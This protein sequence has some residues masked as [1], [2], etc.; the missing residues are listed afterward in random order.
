MDSKRYTIGLDFGTLSARAVLADVS[1]GNIV[2]VSVFGYQDMVIE[3]YLPDTEIKVPSDFALQNPEDY[4]AATTCLLHDI[5]NKAGID[6]QNVIGIGVGFTASTVIAVDEEYTP[7]CMKPEFCSNPHSWVK[8]WKHHGARQEAELINELGEKRQDDF[9]KKYGGK[10]NA[11]LMIPKIFE[12]YRKAPQIYQAT[13]KFMEAS[14]WIVWLLCG[15]ECRSSSSAGLKAFWNKK[16]GYPCKEFFE[17]MDEEFGH[18]V[19]EKLESPVESIGFRAGYLTEKM[20]KETGLHTGVAVSVGASDAV[21]TFPA[22]SVLKENQ[23]ILTLGT[24]ACYQTNNKKEICVPGILGVVEDAMIQGYYGYDAGL[25]AVGDLF[26]WFA[27]RIKPNSSFQQ[28][29]EDDMSIFDVLNQK[30]E[31]LQPGQS[32]LVA[33]DWWNG[34]RSVLGNSDLTGAIIG[35]NLST[36]P[37]EIYRALIE[38]TAFG[39]RVIHENFEKNGIFAEGFVACGGLA[40]KSKTVMQIM[41]DVLGQ[42]IK[43]YDAPQAT[44][45]G[46]AIYG[47]VAAGVEHGGYSNIF[48][49]GGNMGQKKCKI[50]V[51]NQRAHKIYNQLFEI[52]KKLYQYFGVE[53][54]ETMKL[55]KDKK[56]I[57]KEIIN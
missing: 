54:V 19:L 25:T 36:K 32:G 12:T 45:L 42:E 24:S 50:Y 15:Q 16:T 11:E 10:V 53:E 5:W 21:L 43:V 48:V 29:V 22:L 39:V 8:L 51:P 2:A 56:N 49:A 34:N 20:A 30:A 47:A 27:N 44:A 28:A 31:D 7:L 37:E 38:A 4:I 6:P 46:A 18:T 17:E 26:D 52:Y 23:V 14:D 57:K 33:L 3:D 1:S 41:A 55:L 35:M 9:F 40:R 13:Y